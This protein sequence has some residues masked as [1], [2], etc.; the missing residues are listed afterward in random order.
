MYNHTSNHTPFPYLRDLEKKYHNEMY[1]FH[2]LCNLTTVWLYSFSHRI[3]SIYGSNIALMHNKHSD[4]T[5]ES[6]R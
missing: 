5:D 6:E 2:S 3:H 1:G 4:Y